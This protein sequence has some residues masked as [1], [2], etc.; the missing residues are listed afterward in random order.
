MFV[1]GAPG[2]NF[3]I[4]IIKLILWIDVSSISWELLFR[5]MPHYSIDDKSALV[6]VFHGVTHALV[7]INNIIDS[8]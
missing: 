1:K 3:K 6:L 7:E 8:G 5:L 4:T 2:S